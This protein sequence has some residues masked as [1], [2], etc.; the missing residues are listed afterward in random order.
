MQ[1]KRSGHV[2]L[3]VTIVGLIFLQSGR[4]G[5][6]DES[7]LTTGE[8]CDLV[9][10]GGKIVDGTGNPWFIGDVAV[11][12]DRIVAIGKIPIGT[13][14]VVDVPA[15]IDYNLSGIH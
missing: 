4:V 15:H 7:P 1:Q 3:Y 9:L 8:T 11:T 6:A 10:R 12:G 2:A 13:G 14:K 5:N